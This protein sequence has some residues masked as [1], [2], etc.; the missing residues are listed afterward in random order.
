MIKLNYLNHLR[1]SHYSRGGG[2]FRR[3]KR[4]FYPPP[5]RKI[6]A[7]YLSMLIIKK[8]CRPQTNILHVIYTNPPSD[9]FRVHLSSLRFFSGTGAKQT[10]PNI[11]PIFKQRTQSATWKNIRRWTNILN[12][13]TCFFAFFQLRPS[14]KKYCQLDWNTDELIFHTYPSHIHACI[15]Q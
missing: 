4:N 7:T 8:M 5:P 15:R 10:K 1:G 2:G 6:L 3:A 13:F 11:Y 14:F 12:C 9:Q